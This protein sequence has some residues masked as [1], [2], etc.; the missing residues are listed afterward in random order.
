MA[1]VA[2]PRIQINHKYINR[3]IERWLDI[4]FGDTS[5]NGRVTIGRRKNGGGIYTMSVRSLNELRP[6]V[7]MI[8]AS[9][10]LDYYITA[11]TVSG[12]TRRES[13]LFGLQN[14][15][16]DIDCH[17]KESRRD[18]SSLV[19]AFVWRSKRDLWGTG[20][21]PAPNSIVRTG[22]GVQLWWA[23][24][25]CYGG[26]DYGT[27]RYHYDKIKANLMDH[28]EVMLNEYEE[29][30]D[31]LE[32]D[33]GASSNPVGYFRLPCTYNTAAKRYSTLE[34]LHSQ[35]Y[36]QRE[37]TLLAR[38]EVEAYYRKRTDVQE[39][40]PLKR[41][42]IIVLQNFYS[43][44]LRRVMQLVKLRNLRDS[45]IGSETRDHLN[46]A[47]Y[48]ALRMTFD[49]EEA[50][51]RLKSYNE[52]FK[53]PMSDKELENCV[54]SAKKKAGYKYSNMKLI[55]LLNITQ[56]EQNA[57]GLHPFR[58]QYRPWSH[59]KPNASRDA[60][61]KAI[62]EDRDNKILA[63]HQQ[64]VSQAETARL[65]GIGKNTV[66]RVLKKLRDEIEKTDAPSEPIAPYEERHQFGSI[67]VLSTSETAQRVSTLDA[68]SVGGLFVLP[69]YRDSGG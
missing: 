9:P 30:L 50:M 54:V 62:R 59:T 61:R 63:M 39:Y 69:K 49:H 2:A 65:L 8:H 27:S 43:T 5:F 10:R 33:R 22:R 45:E 42:D 51:E 40:V 18:I 56:E 26:R 1:M 36:D 48:N 7:L 11:N 66:G 16:I 64:G 44:G 38:P 13:E 41:S 29:E 24:Q 15:V 32:V 68:H 23:I 17:D 58:G 3:N 20:V 47:V 4:H 57:I 37:L 35:R 21:I 28:I 12:V 34:I 14:I 6:Y 52:G 60:A 19:E 67:Y 55:E 53:Q 31:G 25:P 46:F